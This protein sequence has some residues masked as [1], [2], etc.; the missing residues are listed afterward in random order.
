[1]STASGIDEVSFQEYERNSE[2]NLKDV[3]ELMKRQAYKPH[4]VRRVYIVLLK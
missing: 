3:V 4:P 2:A 1:M